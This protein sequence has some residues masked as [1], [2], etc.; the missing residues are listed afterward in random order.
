MMEWVG[1]LTHAPRHPVLYSIA[2]IVAL[3]FT[4]RRAVIIRRRLRNL[5]YG[6]DGERFTNQFLDQMRED[7]AHVLHDIPGDGFNLDHV[8]LSTRGIYAI[9]TKTWSKPTPKAAITVQGDRLLVAGKEPD[10]NPISQAAANAKWLERILEDSTG[11]PFRVRGVVV[12]P[13]WWID[14]RSS[15]GPVW[16]L[17]PKALPKFIAN[18][19]ETIVASDVTLAA[20][21]LERFIRSA[22]STEA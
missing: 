9:E 18:E 19:P 13:N 10:R 15:R 17:E 8:I 6:R 16:V 12:F 22:S 21:H 11:K 14:Q 20:S 4:V 1:Y 2:A 7:D 5:R 3:I